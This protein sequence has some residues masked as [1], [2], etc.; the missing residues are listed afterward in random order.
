MNAEGQDCG[1]TGGD[2][3]L[4]VADRWILSRL[5]QTIGETRTALDGYRFDL[6]AQAIYEFTWNEYCDWYLELSKPVLTDREASEAAKRGT[7]RTLVRVLETLLRLSTRSCP[8]SP[9]RSG[10][11]SRRWPGPQARPSC[12]SPTRRPT[13]H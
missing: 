2:V 12:A 9:R 5:Q 4:S 6:A 7:R 8:S 13:R 1:Q 3:E 10:R 11:G